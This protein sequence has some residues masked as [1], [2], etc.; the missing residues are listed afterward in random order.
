E[1]ADRRVGVFLGQVSPE[2]VGKAAGYLPRYHGRMQD[3]SAVVGG[4]VAVDADGAG[5]AVDLNAADIED[6]AVAE[7][8]VDFV[9]RCRGAQLGGGPEGGLAD[10]VVELGRLHPRR[11]VTGGRQARK[12]HGIVRVP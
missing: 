7:R 6:E 1:S 4:H 2:R 10:G 9:A 5:A 11:P 8:G 3:A 12:W